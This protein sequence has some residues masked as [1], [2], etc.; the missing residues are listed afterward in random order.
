MP[1]NKKEY[2]KEYNKNKKEFYKQYHIE[3]PQIKKITEW[4]MRG[5]K[6]KD[7]E[8]W[9]S[10]YLFYITWENC[11]LCNVKLTD[12]KNN[13]PTRRNLDHDHETGFIR[14]VLCFKCNR[15]R[16]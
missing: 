4:K 3:N 2:M 14:D 7:N 5:I 11:E 9:E 8:D 13:T 16:K 15:N 10:V 1:F 6:L 12:E